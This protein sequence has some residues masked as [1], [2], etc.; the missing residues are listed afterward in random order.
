MWNTSLA[1]DKWRLS[2]CSLAVAPGRGPITILAIRRERNL[3]GLW[4]YPK[5]DAL[6][7]A[8]LRQFL[9]SLKGW[10]VVAPGKE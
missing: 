2:L 1:C 4:T 6:H 3:S 10:L 7:V 5:C 9:G 8:G